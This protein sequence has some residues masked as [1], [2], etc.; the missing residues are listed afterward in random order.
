MV[1][2]EMI[3]ERVCFFVSPYRCLLRY[4][5]ETGDDHPRAATVGEKGASDF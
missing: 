2:S 5:W 1:I 4:I 3:G